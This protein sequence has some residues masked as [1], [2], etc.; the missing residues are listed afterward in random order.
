MRSGGSN[1]ARYQKWQTTMMHQ[2][3]FICCPKCIDKAYD[4]NGRLGFLKLEYHKSMV[5][6][7]E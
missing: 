3:L 1:V 7:T 5:E 6:D 4:P 2:R